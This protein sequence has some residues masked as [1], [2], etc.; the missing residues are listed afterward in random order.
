MH[1]MNPTIRRASPTD[2]AA[3]ATID[4]KRK[5]AAQTQRAISSHIEKRWRLE[6]EN[7]HRERANHEASLRDLAAIG[8]PYVR[9]VTVFSGE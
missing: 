6:E 4:A 7:I 8:A 2:A 1:S 3:L 9:L 5:R